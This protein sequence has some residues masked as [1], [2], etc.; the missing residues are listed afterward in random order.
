MRF[1]KVLTTTFFVFGVGLL[2]AWP[3]LLGA[4]PTT[5]RKELAEWGI[6]ALLY[7][8]FTTLAFLAS[9]FGAWMIMRRQRQE[10]IAEA[11]E[12]MQNLVEGT[13]KDHGREP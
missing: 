10:F 6:K 4:K 2:L 8:L 5:G 9:A 3:W 13:L 11:K 7:F 12:N 1:L